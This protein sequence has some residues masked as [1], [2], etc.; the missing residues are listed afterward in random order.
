MSSGKVGCISI[1]AAYIRAS[2]SQMLTFDLRYLDTSEY[3]GANLKHQTTGI[4]IDNE[5]ATCIA[6][7]NK[8]TVGN[9][10]VST[11]FYY[12]RQGIVF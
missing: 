2:H 8:N 7:Y 11:R 12:V 1:V 3:N 5:A 6:V 4:L 10:Y 9:R